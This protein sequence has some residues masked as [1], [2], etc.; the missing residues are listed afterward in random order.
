[1]L[2]GLTVEDLMQVNCPNCGVPVALLKSY[3]E[4]RKKDQKDFYCPNGHKHAFT[5]PGDSDEVKGLKDQIS[6]L[7][8]RVVQ[9]EDQLSMRE[10]A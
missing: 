8:L 10:Q 4:Q 5:R 7:K 9:L 3:V 2:M 6:R 1:M